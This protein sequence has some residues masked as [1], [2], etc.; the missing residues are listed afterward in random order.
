LFVDGLTTTQR[1]VNIGAYP[2]APG[3]SYAGLAQTAKSHDPSAEGLQ[4]AAYSVT[5][6]A[7]QV[8][9]LDLRAVMGASGGGIQLR[10]VTPAN[11]TVA[12][13][14]AVAAATAA[15][16]AVIFAYDEGTEG[17]DRGGSNQQTGIALPGYQDALISAVAAAQPNTV[18][19]LNTGDPVL[20]PWA[21]QVKSILE[22]W[23][24][25][26]MGGPATADVLLGNPNPGGPLPVTF[27]ADNTHFPSFDPN[28]NPAT[29]AGCDRYPGVIQS[30]HSYRTITDMDATAGNG[31]FQGYRWYD[32]NGVTPLFEFGH[33][34]SYTT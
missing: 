26:Q 8:L 9:H 24:P 6:T 17:S 16:K 30:P 5:L 7:G 4:Q 2:A 31:I 27:P 32:K 28:C 21:S 11:Q 25:G 12:I 3:S 29:L 1:R 22:M 34:L 33:G 13:A 19:V 20:M 23:Y 14:Q 15:K 10:R 18:V